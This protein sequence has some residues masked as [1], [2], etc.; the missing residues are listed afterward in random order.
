MILILFI[1]CYFSFLECYNFTFN[2]SV[3]KFFNSVSCS[4]LFFFIVLVTQWE[5]LIWKFISFRFFKVLFNKHVYKLLLSSFSVSFLLGKL[6][7]HIIFSGWF[8]HLPFLFLLRRGF[9][10]IEVSTNLSCHHFLKY[11]GLFLIT[12]PEIF[13]ILRFCNILFFFKDATSCHSEGS[14]YGIL[15]SFP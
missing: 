9:L 7:L 5:F 6:V 14:N 4:W 11:F 13:H 1:S 8:L 2:P 12:F 3:L 15:N 10:F